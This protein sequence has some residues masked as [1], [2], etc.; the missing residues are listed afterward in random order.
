MAAASVA[1]T[2]KTRK[3]V[4]L[5]PERFSP[6]LRAQ[7][8]EGSSGLAGLLADHDLRIMGAWRGYG[9]QFGGI[10]VPWMIPSL[11]L[12]PARP[13]GSLARTCRPARAALGRWL[14][15]RLPG[16]RLVGHLASAG[17]SALNWRSLILAKPLARL[18]KRSLGLD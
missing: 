12:V 1:T 15:D 3:C 6:I 4:T 10:Q 8:L 2:S 13:I 17:S 16:C 5:K 11:L 9:V 18:R 14:A 7:T